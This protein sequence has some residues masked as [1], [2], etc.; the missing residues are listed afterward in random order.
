MCNYKFPI[1]ISISLLCA[2][3]EKEMN[4][5]KCEIDAIKM[6]TLATNDECALTADLKKQAR[7]KHEK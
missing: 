7:K 5:T 1:F 6:E 2:E 3:V 4:R